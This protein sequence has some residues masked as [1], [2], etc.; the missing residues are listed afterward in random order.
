METKK[1]EI[2][3]YAT[4][5]S[6]Y[7]VPIYKLLHSDEEVSLTV[8]Y[9]SD[10]GI[11]EFYDEQS[12]SFI[13]WD[14]DLSEGY[15]Y[16]VFKNLARRNSRNFFRAINFG[17]IP[18]LLNHKY[19]LVLINGYNTL[20]SWLV[21]FTCKLLRIKLVWRGEALV[22]KN[23]PPFLLAFLKK[24][25]L[26]FYFSSFNYV[27]YSCQGN[28]DY[29]D[30]YVRD[31]NKL[32]IFPC[33]VDNKFFSDIKE[34]EYANRKE[35]RR[36]LG[37]NDDE[38]VVLFAARFIKRKRP[39]DLINAISKIDHSKVTLLF[40]G[41]GPERSEM[42]RVVES[43][44]IKSIFTGLLGQK[45]LARHYMISDLYALLSDY[46]ASPKT[47]NEALN[48]GLPI[49]ASNMLGNAPDIVIEEKNGFIVE[50]GDH[51]QIINRLNYLIKNLEQMKEKSLKVSE[52]LLPQ[53]SIQ[54]DVQAIKDLL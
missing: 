23:E 41:D 46:D 35:I 42:Q 19:D 14:I 1:N 48:F 25:I 6:Q 20:T 43:Y 50:V 13:N 10:V 28:K 5:A 18:W 53:W 27:F 22:P 24:I 47:L 3:I 4:N 51:Q 44:S 38:I 31:K 37:I 9:G 21:F 8:L 45:E 34:N 40:C 16:K 29:L 39:Y 26:P 17:I 30:Q 2:A 11:E 36:S 33:A 52:L 49:I 7:H 54:R 15:N 32:K 12:S